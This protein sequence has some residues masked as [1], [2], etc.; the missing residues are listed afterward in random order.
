MK[1]VSSISKG[2]EKSNFTGVSM[3]FVSRVHAHP[4]YH[5][6]LHASIRSLVIILTLLEYVTKM[7]LHLLVFYLFIETREFEV[8]KSL[9]SP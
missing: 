1:S 8:M 7:C 6:T 9:L 4:I 2:R 3:Y 5:P